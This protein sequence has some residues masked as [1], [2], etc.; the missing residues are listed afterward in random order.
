M[1]PTGRT[2]Q[3][4]GRDAQRPALGAEPPPPDRESRLREQ[5]KAALVDN[6]EEV[7]IKEVVGEHVHVLELPG[8]EEASRRLVQEAWRRR[9]DDRSRRSER[10]RGGFPEMQEWPPQPGEWRPL[11]LLRMVGIT[12]AS[13]IVCLL[14][15]RALSGFL[16]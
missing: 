7:Q 6:P 15:F 8:A 2:T 5:V 12:G 4:Q 3:R 14:V 13:L 10:L 11:R 16:Q 9:R 1:E